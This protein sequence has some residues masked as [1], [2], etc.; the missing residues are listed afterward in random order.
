M[1]CSRR[2]WPAL[3]ACIFAHACASALAG[4]KRSEKPRSIILATTTST[5]DSGLLDA[6]L[7]TFRASTGI[8]VKVVAVGTGQALEIGK[9]GDADV[10]LV[11]SAKAEEAFMATG[12]GESRKSVMYNDFVIAGPKADPAQ[13][14]GKSA[15]GA[16][17][18]IAS[19]NALFVSRGDNSGTHLAEQEIWRSIGTTAHGDGYKSVGQGMTEAL[20]MANQL[21]AY[22]LSDRAT[23]LAQRKEIAL[24]VLVEKD[25][26]L[27]NPYSVIVVKTTRDDRTKDD[28]RRFSAFLLEPATQKAIAEYGV[29]RDGEA[30][31]FVH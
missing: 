28:A 12:R 19:K 24:V 26:A 13:I 31:F 17:T 10:L 1:A 11:H 5:R 7:P 20:R 8:E 27:V 21:G 25:P 6:L 29:A 9:R 16:F 14:A 4:C 30:S 22:V 18:I 2:W 23:F 15:R 3:L